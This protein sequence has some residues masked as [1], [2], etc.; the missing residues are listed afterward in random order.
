[1]LTKTQV[2]NMKKIILFIIALAL[3]AAVQGY[4]QEHYTEGHTYSCIYNVQPIIYNNENFSIE[5]NFD[6]LR[7]TIDFERDKLYDCPSSLPL[8]F[9]LQSSSLTTQDQ[10]YL[11][12]GHDYTCNYEVKRNNYDITGLSFSMVQNTRYENECRD[13]VLLIF[14]KVPEAI[15]ERAQPQV[16][17]ELEKG[18][19]VN[20][21]VEDPQ[22]PLSN[23]NLDISNSAN[24][25]EV[26]VVAMETKPSPVS[27]IPS[28]RLAYQY[29]T[30]RENN[31]ENSL[32]RARFR[33]H[34]SNEWLASQDI[35]PETVALSRFNRGM[36]N[37]LPTREVESGMASYASY[38][39]VSPGLSY[40][41]ITAEKQE[42][43]MTEDR[44]QVPQI[45]DGT[46]VIPVSNEDQDEDFPYAAI[47]LFTLL[48]LVLVGIITLAVRRNKR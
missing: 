38:E 19:M 33:F 37:Q 29:L 22:I 28:D 24:N 25:P 16:W 21:E 9:G 32:N 13:E 42:T 27:E 41:V 23:I 20:Y 14:D 11:V 34:V 12:E 17:S 46:N 18:Q 30:V 47:V 4:D 44:N 6:P 36:W 35:E 10:E 43:Q 48:A 3:V 45:E 39:A 40:F 5:G 7:A 31:L 26:S 15:R 8:L 1:M 2:I